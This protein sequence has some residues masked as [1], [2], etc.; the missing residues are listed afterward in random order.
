MRLRDSEKSS[1]VKVWIRGIT[2]YLDPNQPPKEVRELDMFTYQTV[3]IKCFAKFQGGWY[4]VDREGKIHFV[5]RA[6]YL[7]TLK[8]WAEIA[9]NDEFIANIK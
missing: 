6:L 1:K 3:G 7:L 5:T 4:K 8:E 9:V 2:R